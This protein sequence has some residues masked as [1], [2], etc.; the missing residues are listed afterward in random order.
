MHQVSNGFVHLPGF[1]TKTHFNGNTRAAQAS[2]SISDG[3]TEY[4][5]GFSVDELTF[6]EQTATGQIVIQYN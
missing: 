5:V 3:Q 1:N 2:G 4:A 6:L